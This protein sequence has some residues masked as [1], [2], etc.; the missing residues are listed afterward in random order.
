VDNDFQ[1]AVIDHVDNLYYS[2]GRPFLISNR[3]FLRVCKGWCG[4]RAIWHAQWN[5]TEAL[6]IPSVEKSYVDYFDTVGGVEGK[7]RQDFVLNEPDI[8][9]IVQSF[10]NDEK[11]PPRFEL[12]LHFLGFHPELAEEYLSE[13]G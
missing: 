8:Q 1:S 12:A 9:A 13:F 11:A 7:I 6:T 2:G 5:P 10:L 3:P 4:E